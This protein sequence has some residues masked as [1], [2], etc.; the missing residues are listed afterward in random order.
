MHALTKHVTCLRRSLRREL[1]PTELCIDSRISAA[2][3]TVFGRVCDNLWEFLPQSLGVSAART[4]PQYRMYRLNRMYR[5]VRNRIDRI[6]AGLHM[7]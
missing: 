4:S 1:K 6:G 2:L 3:K 5:P 7:R